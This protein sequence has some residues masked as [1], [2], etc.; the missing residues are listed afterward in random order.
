M[1]RSE[2]NGC[3]SQEV[4]SSTQPML[5]TLG[6][7]FQNMEIQ[8]YDENPQHQHPLRTCH[9][10]VLMVQSSQK[11]EPQQELSFPPANQVKA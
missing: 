10:M 9:Q 4:Q 11:I 3:I 1:L 2:P 6:Y 8:F 5:A 7:D